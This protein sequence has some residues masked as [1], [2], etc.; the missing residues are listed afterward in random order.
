MLFVSL[1]ELCASAVKGG[2]LMLDKSVRGNIIVLRPKPLQVNSMPNSDG[3][4]AL[5][6]AED[7][8]G[9]RTLLE[10]AF[11][12]SGIQNRLFFAEDGQELINYMNEAIVYSDMVKSSYLVLLDLQ[13][14]RLNGFDTLKIL[15]KDV[16]FKKIP[17]VILTSSALEEDVAKT[18]EMGANSFFK[19]PADYKEFLDLAKLIKKYW[20]QKSVL[21]G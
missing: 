21:P 6:I 16:R 11:L 3:K 8:Q 20:L 10:K 5:L 1:C 15:K 14:P 13:M 9:D 19:K 4:I 7:N 12:E 18:Y 17:V 2:I